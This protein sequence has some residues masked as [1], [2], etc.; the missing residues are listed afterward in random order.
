MK[1]PIDIVRKEDS[2]LFKRIVDRN[3]VTN[4]AIQEICAELDIQCRPAKV[5]YIN[6]ILREGTGEQKELI[7]KKKRSIN[8]TYEELN[9]SNTIA[10]DV[11]LKEYVRQISTHPGGYDIDSL[12]LYFK[13]MNVILSTVINIKAI[14]SID[15]TFI[16][17]IVSTINM[18]LDNIYSYIITEVDI[19]RK[20][21]IILHGIDETVCYLQTLNDNKKILRYYPG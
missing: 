11:L 2:L 16:E 7:L 21:Y 19:M 15:E 3:G 6:K 8:E 12:I 10:C 4:A 9:N 5:S 18:N 20:I 14:S 13:Q 1:R 17:E